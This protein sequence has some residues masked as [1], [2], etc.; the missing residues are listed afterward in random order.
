MTK[1]LS[2]IDDAALLDI[3]VAAE[4]A[5]REG[6]RRGINDGGKD[7]EW[8]DP[9]AKLARKLTEQQN[10]CWEFSGWKAFLADIRHERAER[11]F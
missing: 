7:D 9:A 10:L 11:G 6:T 4:D 8:L 1:T 2:E 3:E 5:V